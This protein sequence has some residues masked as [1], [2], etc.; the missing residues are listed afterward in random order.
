MNFVRSKN[1][2]KN[3]NLNYGHFFGRAPFKNSIIQSKCLNIPKMYSFSNKKYYS[4]DYI[5]LY[6]KNRFGADYMKLPSEE[7]KMKYPSHCVES[8]KS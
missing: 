8:F 7:V 3:K 5:D 2:S 6:L 1:N 4:F